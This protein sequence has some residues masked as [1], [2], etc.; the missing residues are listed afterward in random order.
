MGNYGI[1]QYA[2]IQDTKA[3]TLKEA[4]FRAPGGMAGAQ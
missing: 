2:P 1:A 4:C 3:E